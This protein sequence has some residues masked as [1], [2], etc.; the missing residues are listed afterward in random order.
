MRTNKLW[1]PPATN[2]YWIRGQPPNGN[3]TG[4]RLS[5]PGATLFKT[6]PDG[7]WIFFQGRS[8]CDVVAIEVCGTIQNLNDK[9]SRYMPASHSLVVH[10]EADWLVEKIRVQNGG[11]V[12][13]WQAS[14]K[15]NKAPKKAIK[16]PVRHLRVLYCL[17]NK[18][19]QKWR[20]EHVP[21]GYEFYC[22]HSSLNSF[23][24]Q[25]MQSFLRQMSIESQFYT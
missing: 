22:P 8:S 10:C 18:I 25:K 12:E 13:R 5:A 19:Y 16:V 2:G 7:L 15:F 9:R 24:S 23:N 1:S 6:Q 21:T 4:P 11:K 3:A 14:G 17:P 20:K